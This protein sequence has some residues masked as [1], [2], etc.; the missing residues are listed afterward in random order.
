MYLF[1]FG[2]HTHKRLFIVTRIL[3]ISLLK[4]S[5]SKSNFSHLFKF[6]F[7]LL[8]L[9]SESNK[10]ENPTYCFSLISAY[11]FCLIIYNIVK[12]KTMI[13]SFGEHVFYCGKVHLTKF[14]ILTIKYAVQWYQRHSHGCATVTLHYPTF[15]PP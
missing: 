9:Y 8:L 12:T 3:N 5:A 2:A 1:I 4:Q 14:T 6:K 11:R 7:Q 10:F 13:F 15:F